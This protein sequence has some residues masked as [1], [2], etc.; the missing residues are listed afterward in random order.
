MTND[1]KDQVS[2]RG[3]KNIPGERR[4]SMADLKEISKSDK[5]LFLLIK[6]AI[7]REI[8]SQ[9]MYREALA[10]C[11]DPVLKKVLERLLDQE[12]MHEKR[13]QHMYKKLRQE[14][15]PDGKPLPGQKKTAHSSK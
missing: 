11:A 9:E 6:T 5:K 12:I 13:L 4:D 3:E 10:Y 1:D 2:L 7:D 8:A 15:D 14:I